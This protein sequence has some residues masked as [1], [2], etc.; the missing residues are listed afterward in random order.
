MDSSQKYDMIRSLAKEFA[1]TE[2]TKE[3]LDEAEETGQLSF[4]VLQKMADA[5]FFGI[6]IPVKYGGQGGDCMAYTIVMEELC[7]KSTVAG[8][9]VS[10]ANSLGSAPI[11]TAGTEE[12]KNRYLPG[13]ADGTGRTCFGL[14]E[15]G[16]GSDAA[17]MQTK[18]VKDGSEYVINGS[19]CFISMA[20][21]SDYGII[22]AK[23]APFIGTKSITAFI[24]DL[25]LPGVSFGKPENKMGIEGCPTSDI[26]FEDVRIPESCRLGAE[27]KG[28]GLAMGTLDLGRMG[29]AAQALGTAVGCLN[30]SINY[31]KERKQ[32]GKPIGKFQSLSFMLADMATDVEAMRRLTYY[33]AEVR[34][35]G[36]KDANAACMAKLFCGEKV[37]E[38]A[39]KAVQIHGG[40]GYMKEY[41]V[42]R[43]YR[44][45]RILSIYE[46]TSQVQQMVISGNLMR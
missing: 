17:S 23:T 13:I 4:E 27:G 38:I 34:D 46:G 20:P 25:H 10:L 22:F 9:Y 30:E 7:Q 28:Y 45:A 15:P 24:V 43:K 6:K 26:V 37:N 33:S 42:E 18:A 19:K 11:I 41:A 2:F 12:Q 39:Y 31:A 36:L 8:V 16:A 5:G 40:Y 44:D 35:K 29:A 32:F 14:T 21:I 3:V 1:E